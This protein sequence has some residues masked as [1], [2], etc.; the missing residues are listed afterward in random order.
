M[1]KR[2]IM[3]LGVFGLVASAA[4]AA[5]AGEALLVPQHGALFEKPPQHVPTQGMA[6]GPLL[7]NGDVG[8]VLA[9]PP[10]T[11]QFH[12]GKN[13]F[14]RRNDASVMAVGGVSLAIPALHGASYHQEQDLA[15]GEVRGTFSKD[16]LT[17]RTRSWVSA[18]ENLQVTSIRC[19]GSTPVAVVVR[20]AVGAQVG[21]SAQLVDNGRPINIGREQH[22]NARWYFDGSI[23]DVRIEPQALTAEEIRALAKERRIGESPKRFDGQRTFD[24]RPSPRVEKAV[25]VAAWIKIEGVGTEANYIVSRGE[26]NQ[27]YSL[28]LAAGCLRWASG[29]PT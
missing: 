29:G 11:Q 19:E 9:G 27:A 10:E 24:E 20:Q 26:W 6:D 2:L 5:L 17:L 21:R 28:G 23:E 12:I 25:T 15:R 3:R 8:V 1:K 4:I 7:G 22:G 13:D 14:W 16:V 18:E